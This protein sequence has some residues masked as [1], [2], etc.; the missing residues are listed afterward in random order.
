MSRPVPGASDASP[1]VSVIV[2]AYN[3]EATIRACIE[4]L[5]AQD[6]PGEVEV[7][8]VDNGS[9]DRTREAVSEYP[10]RLVLE[11]DAIGSYAAR[12]KG[13]EAARGPILAFTDADCV[14][15]PH[16]ISAAL[17]CFAD[18][19]TYVVGG[20][21]VPDAPASDV[22]RFLVRQGALSQ[23]RAMGHRYLP[24][25]ATANVFFRR[26][27]FERVGPFNADLK[28]GGDVD[29]CWRAQEAGLGPLRLAEAAIVHHRHRANLPEMLRQQFKWGL[30]AGCLSR[31]HGAR[32]GPVRRRIERD[33]YRRIASA[34]ARWA[35]DLPGALFGGRDGR[36]RAR[37][38]WWEVR[39]ALAWK[40]GYR[41]GLHR[42]EVTR[43]ARL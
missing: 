7:I 38:A 24:Y 27:V 41:I 14:P 16:W 5:L 25:F 13:V 9:T 43:T 6:C 12:N 18:P 23:S 21:I 11:S 35:L 4:A 29:L 40:R 39:S 30:G 19:D 3:E 17:A 31:L 8:V 42:P 36:V 34:L 32:M 22:E 20:E 28:S 33:G 10:V 2:P 15:A 37:E 26:E 1:A